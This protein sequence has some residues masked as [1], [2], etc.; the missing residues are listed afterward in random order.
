[1]RTNL[2]KRA[3]QMLRN[4]PDGL[5]VRELATALGA[6]D[7]NVRSRLRLMPDVYIDRYV[8]T[9]TTPTAVW[10]VVVPPP[11]CPKPE[12]NK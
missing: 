9:A 8:F 1:M 3:R 12:R 7:S 10:C 5:T 4:N 11:N 2:A 6:N